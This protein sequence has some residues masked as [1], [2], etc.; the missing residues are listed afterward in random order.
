MTLKIQ[1]LSPLDKGFYAKQ[2]NCHGIPIKSALEIADE[3]LLEAWTRLDMMLRN[4][5]NV[6]ANLSAAGVQ[7]H[8]IGKDQVTSDLPENLHRKGSLIDGVDID[9]RTRGLGGQL[10]SC[11]EE[12]LLKLSTDRYRGSDICVHE[13]AHT[14]LTY[15][16]CDASHKT[17]SNQYKA[18]VEKGLWNGCYAATNEE[19]FFA[20]LAMWY[21]GT[22]GA[23]GLIEPPPTSGPDWLRSYDSDAFA[24][25]DDIF[26]GRFGVSVIN[27]QKLLPVDPVRERDLVSESGSVSTTI[28]IINESQEKLKIYWLN[29]EGV[30]V[31]F[32]YIYPK[33]QFS[34]PTFDTH[35][36]LLT[37]F[38]DQVVVIYV[39]TPH[40]GIALVS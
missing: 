39:A 11:G 6:T 24:V 23:P 38:Q 5:P 1:L 3:A 8:I 21:F 13:F 31:F 30:R 32:A 9:L 15:G 27:W 20:E 7:L 10:A 36:W 19:E 25:L 18:S 35:V 40:P 22:Q 16:L 12:N 33:E 29:Y 26:S 37:D 28:R 4:Q 14:I 17:V 2:L 34:Q